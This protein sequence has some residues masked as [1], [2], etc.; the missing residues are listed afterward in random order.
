MKQ[1]RSNSTDK[2]PLLCSFSSLSTHPS[3]NSLFPLLFFLCAILVVTLLFTF[4]TAFDSFYSLDSPCLT[5]EVLDS[6]FPKRIIQNWKTHNL[7]TDFLHFT[8]SWRS[9]NPGYNYTLYD[10]KE[11]ERIVQDEFPEYLE[12]YQLVPNGA[13]RSDIF[14][15][16]MIYKYGGVY[17]DIDT[18]C[19]RP[20]K[21]WHDEH[22]EIG[23][24]VGIEADLSDQEDWQGKG[25][26][27]Q[28]SLVQWGFAAAPKHSA[29]KALLDRIVDVT[30]PIYGKQE[31]AHTFNT[32]DVDAWTGPAVFTDAIF[33]YVNET[34]GVNWRAFSNLKE[35][36][37]VG[38]IMVLPITG[39]SPGVGHSGDRGIWDKE[40][41]LQHLF[42]GSWKSK[43]SA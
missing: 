23:L 18:M 41:R 35:P 29:I 4:S 25:W 37:V 8:D 21:G 7:T 9:I 27:R 17:A 20:M 19:L 31:K 15:Y 22:M 36:K 13:M 2:M 43:K 38:D 33:G 34:F 3:L 24:M 42:Y 30:T 12:L 40:A 5:Q 26:S 39:F 16:L 14:R 32:N 11:S 1:Q 6:P 28:L 10:D